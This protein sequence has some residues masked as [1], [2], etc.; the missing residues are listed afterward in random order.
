L[1]T[2]SAL[3]GNARGETAVAIKRVMMSLCAASATPI[4][5]RAQ[6]LDIPIA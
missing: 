5:D 4:I 6:G 1:H 3:L 2:H